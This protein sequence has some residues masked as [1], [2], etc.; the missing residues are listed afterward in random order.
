MNLQNGK[1]NECDT[2][3]TSRKAEAK[4]SICENHIIPIFHSVSL[5]LPVRIVNISSE[6]IK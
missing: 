4:Q 2:I 6:Q 3:A 5:Q 1:I